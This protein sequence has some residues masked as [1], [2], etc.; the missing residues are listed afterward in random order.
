MAYNILTV[1]REF[2]SGGHS[3]AK[4]VANRLGIPFYDREIVDKIALETGFSPEFI[5]EES[6]YAKSRSIFAY[7]FSFKG[8][9]GVMGGLSP[10]DYLW[11]VQKK[12]ILEVAQKGPCVIIGRCADHILKDRTDVLHVF[13]HAD[14]EYRA[15]RIVALYGETDKPAIKRLEE[16]DG[17]RSYHYRHFTDKVWG[18]SQNYHLSLDSHVMGE[19]RCVDLIVDLIQGK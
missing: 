18:M 16:K 6:E 1:S 3:I 12:V 17:K 9:P 10:W 13:I 11:T 7:A 19:K 5:V 15:Q 8:T 4:E 14:K 2:G